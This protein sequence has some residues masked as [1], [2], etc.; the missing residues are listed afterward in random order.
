[1]ILTPFSLSSI[2]DCLR[3]FEKLQIAVFGR[4]GFTQRYVSSTK[5]FGLSKHIEMS[6]LSG[7][8]NVKEADRQVNLCPP[9]TFSTPVEQFSPLENFTNGGGFDSPLQN[10]GGFGIHREPIA[11]ANFSGLGSS[12]SPSEFAFGA[13]RDIKEEVKQ[14]DTWNFKVGYSSPS[15]QEIKEAPH[16]G[17]TR[18]ESRHENMEQTYFEPLL[19]NLGTELFDGGQSGGSEAEAARR[20]RI[21]SIFLLCGEKREIA[22]HKGSAPSSTTE[23]QESFPEASARESPA[24][25]YLYGSQYF[26]ENQLDQSVSDFSTSPSQSETTYTDVSSLP[27]PMPA[28]SP[29]RFPSPRRPTRRI[30]SS[31]FA[32]ENSSQPQQE[33]ERTDVYVKWEKS[34]DPAGGKLICIVNVAKTVSLAELREEV[35][36]HI[37]V[38][39][40]NFKFLILGVSYL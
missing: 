15:P 39:K 34:T 10:W 8:N 26:T 24:S 12:T 27:S 14:H 18:H 6:P 19:S 38:A 36:A 1:M 28:V 37:P 7:A 40:K 16:S 17:S 2:V 22:A 4:R 25:Q 13:T 35:E 23:S 11:S 9:L 32:N 31:I 3:L 30:T 33:G 5:F 21:E 29:Q 20:A